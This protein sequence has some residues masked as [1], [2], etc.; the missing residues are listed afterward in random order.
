MPSDKWTAISKVAFDTATK[1][2]WED[3]ADKFEN[4]VLALANGHDRA[5]H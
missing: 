4:V 2:S 5:R 1:Y 3:A